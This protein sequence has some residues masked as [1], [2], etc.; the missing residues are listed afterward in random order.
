MKAGAEI[1]TDRLLLRHWTGSTTDRTAFHRLFSDPEVMRFFPQRL[2][3]AEADALLD[4]LFP[5]IAEYGFGWAALCL[6]DKEDPIGFAGLMPVR[7]KAAFAPTVEIGWR[8]LPEHWG[9]GYA[10]EAANALLRNGFKDL[11]LDEIVSFAVHDNHASTAVMIRIGMIPEPALDFDHPRV[12]DTHPHLK[13]HVFY[14][15]T[16][17]DWQKKRAAD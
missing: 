8:V 12:P 11:H 3:R 15:L 10:T 13:R 1:I 2:A 4:G 7:F 16:R 14:R 5:L 9:K 17:A 6:K